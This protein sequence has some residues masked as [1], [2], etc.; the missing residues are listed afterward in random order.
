MSGR[1]TL[2]MPDRLPEDPLAFAEALDWLRTCEGGASHGSWLEFCER[3]GIFQLLT[4]EY[5]KIL[6]AHL[7]PLAPR[8]VLEVGA[9]GGRLAAALRT[10]ALNVVATDP[11]GWPGVASPTWVE[12][13]GTA[14]ALARHDP[15]LVIGA[16]LPADTP[17]HRQVLSSPGV[18]WYCVID[19][20][21]N[22]VVGAEML[23]DTP[24][25]AAT[26]LADADRWALTRWDCLSE[27]T[28]GEL[29]Q[30]GVTLLFAREQLSLPSIP[31]DPKT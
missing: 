3:H 7:K 22:G 8:R 19:H 26:R 14:E 6:A 24:G 16:W 20:E 15:D 18:R 25:W 10:H 12:Q 11:G 28:H 21:Q 29:I 27:I 2:G 31:A 13:M 17:S 9:G 23:A 30:H 4:R 5:V 1:R